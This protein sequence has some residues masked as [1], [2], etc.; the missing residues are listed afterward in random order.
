ME[1]SFHSY[2]NI[3]DVAL[4]AQSMEPKLIEPIAA[5]TD[6]EIKVAIYKRPPGFFLLRSIKHTLHSSYG[7]G[8]FVVCSKRLS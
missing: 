1:D 3:T 5:A 8:G 7:G 4:T 2:T 6:V